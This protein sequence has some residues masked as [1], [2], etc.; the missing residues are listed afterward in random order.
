MIAVGIR[1][2]EK[3]IWHI[4]HVCVWLCN[5]INSGHH[6]IIISLWV[7]GMMHSSVCI[8]SAIFRK[9]SSFIDKQKYAYVSITDLFS[10]FQV[11]IRRD[12]RFH[13]T[14]LVCQAWIRLL[15]WNKI[16]TGQKIKRSAWWELL[17]SW[18]KY[19][20]QYS[21]IHLCVWQQI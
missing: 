8:S 13:F 6:K 3:W 16:S 9:F 5:M 4:L 2:N 10:S 7:L 18:P 21:Y 17:L 19:L 11:M 14:T 12:P 20:M 1:N 15:E